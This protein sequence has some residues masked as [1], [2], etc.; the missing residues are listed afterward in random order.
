MASDSTEKC[1]SSPQLSRSIKLL[2][3]SQW[4]I[5]SCDIVTALNI[6][7]TLL[8][9]CFL[10]PLLLHAHHCYVFHKILAATAVESHIARTCLQHLA[11][12]S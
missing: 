6:I 10:I 5:K 12:N 9:G 7:F 2:P 4:L 11:H 8:W 3:E 1:T